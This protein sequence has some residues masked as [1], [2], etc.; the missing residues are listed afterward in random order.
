MY[1]SL[2]N[3]IVQSSLVFLRI[4]FHLFIVS[5]SSKSL[6]TTN[7][8]YYFFYHFFHFI[9][10]ALFRL[11]YSWNRTAYSPSNWI[12]FLNSMHIRFFFVFL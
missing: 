3:I 7:Y 12:L 2:Y 9:V 8:Y 5:L 10:F 4:M 11:S 6:T 1:M